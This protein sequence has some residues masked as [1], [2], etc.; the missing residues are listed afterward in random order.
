MKQSLKVKSISAQTFT[1]PLYKNGFLVLRTIEHT[2]LNK[3]C[4]HDFLYMHCDI[5]R[6]NFIAHINWHFLIWERFLLFP[7]EKQN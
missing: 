2:P 6:Q 1:T 7:T 3:M 4:G 5:G